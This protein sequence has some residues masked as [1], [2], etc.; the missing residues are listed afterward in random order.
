MEIQ[1]LDSIE[2][3]LFNIKK[4]NK[5]SFKELVLNVVI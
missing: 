1:G 4:E 3:I 2:K 5:I